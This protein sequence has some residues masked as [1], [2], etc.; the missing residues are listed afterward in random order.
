MV[1]GE[2]AVDRVPGRRRDERAVAGRAAEQPEDGEAGEH[3]R[4]GETRRADAVLGERCARTRCEERGAAE[5]ALRVKGLF[6]LKVSEKRE[7]RALRPMR[8]VA[9]RVWWTRRGWTRLVP[10]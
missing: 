2:R 8:L 3:R 9:G 10:H 1:D 6:E 4:G 7:A 5:Q